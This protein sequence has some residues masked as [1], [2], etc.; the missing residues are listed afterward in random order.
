MRYM[1]YNVLN[2]GNAINKPAKKI[3]WLFTVVNHVQPDLLSV[4]EMFSDSTL[5]DSLLLGVLG[6][7]WEKTPFSNLGGQTQTNTLFYRSSVFRLRSQTVVSFALRDI[8]AY[9]LQNTWI[10]SP[11]RTTPSSLP[12]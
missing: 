5:R 10:P 6:P 8:V 4:N 12:P 3:S 9:R 1:H 11:G 7:G 2:Y